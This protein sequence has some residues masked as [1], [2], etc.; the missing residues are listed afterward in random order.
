MSD[1]R[2]YAMWDEAVRLVRKTLVDAGFRLQWRATDAL[3]EEIVDEVLGYVVTQAEADSTVVFGMDGTGPFCSWCGRWPGPK[4]TP[5]HPQYGV[6]CTC[7][8]V[9]PEE[10][11]SAP[12][13]HEEPQ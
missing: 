6:F 12:A 1:P 4:M 8:R 7:V 3:A 2:K 9:E 13:V 5:E 10:D 11:R